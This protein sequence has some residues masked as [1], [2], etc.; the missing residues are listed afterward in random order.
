MLH[1]LFDLVKMAPTSANCQSG[2][3]AF[4]CT[5]EGRERLRPTLAA[6]D[7]EFFT[8][9]T[10]R[11]NFLVNLG[12]GDTSSLQARSPRPAFEDSCRLV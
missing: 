9:T 5:N 8:S 11:S 12:Y 2:R 4:V 1:R 7:R 10:L 6:V 3:F